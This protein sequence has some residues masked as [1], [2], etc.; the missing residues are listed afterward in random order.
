MKKKKEKKK[1]KDLVIKMCG[2]MKLYEMAG[3][4]LHSKA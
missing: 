3:S 4:S 1:E 2:W